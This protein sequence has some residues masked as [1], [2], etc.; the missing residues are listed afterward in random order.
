MSRS[1]PDKRRPAAAAL[2][3]GTAAAL[4]LLATVAQPAAHAA[5]V[6]ATAAAGAAVLAAGPA[7][8]AAL[9]ANQPHHDSAADHTWTEADVAAVSLTGSGATTTSPNVTVS[10]QTITVTAAGTY[11]FSGS[12]T[13]GQIAVNSPGT[14]LVR[15]IL[16]GVTVAN[17]TSSA[18]NVIAADEVMVVLQAGSTNRLSDASVYSYPSGVDEPNAA[19]FSA[20]DTT[21]TGT[22]T[23]TVT[24]NAYDGIASKDGL[25]IDS[26]TITVT[27]KD[28]GIRG[29]DYVYVAGG[30]IT[31][32]S[33][34]DGVTADND[35]DTTRGYVYVGAGTV[36]ATST[37]GDAING[38][39]DV[40]VTGGT[41]TA[42]AGGGSTVTPG[43][44]STKGVKAG[45]L[46][47]ISEGRTTIDASDDGLHSDGGVTVDGGTTTIATGD[48][49]VHAETDVRISAGTVTVSRSYEGIEGLKVFLSGG[50]ISATAT[51]DAV[52][53][54]DPATGEM[55]NSPNALISVTGGTVVVSGGTDGLDSNGALAVGGGTVVVNGS[56]T[57]GGGEGGLDANGAL[58]I[59]AGVLLSAGISSSTSTLP[60]SGQGWV[61]VTFSA[62]QAA[63]TIVHLATT[64][65]TQL[66][67]FQS[68][69]A[70]RSVVF[71]SAQIT[72]GTTYAIRTGGAV[73]GTAVG[74]G[75]YTGGTLSGTQVTTVTAGTQTRG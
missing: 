64:S 18:V 74:G 12:L 15:L 1:A 59:T 69:K 63:G 49:G 60:S 3:I 55:Q 22:G 71:S 40:I 17:S 39:T 11:R 50:T 51:D 25:Y 58:T 6:P 52:N 68:T 45:V 42:K 9:A 26:G 27:A 48:D 30:T 2:A 8:A 28:D 10:G 34:G 73:S 31:A 43:T 33:A 20:A 75:L 13:N 36:N 16:N 14:G 72:R 19:L 61:Q 62:N 46:A 23:L 53:A 37:A 56:P 32:T 38:E 70:F 65:G 47:V 41:V 4:G 35:E 66:A 24:G 21:I 57:R 29:R 5:V 54:S 7:A 67:A 44:A